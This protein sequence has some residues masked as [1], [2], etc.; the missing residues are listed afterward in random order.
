MYCSPTWAGV[1]GVIWLAGRVWYAIGYISAAAKRGAGFGVSAG[2]ASILI[3]GAIIGV[4]MK[5]L[6]GA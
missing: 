6:S 1:L 4:V 5:M 2:A 3:V